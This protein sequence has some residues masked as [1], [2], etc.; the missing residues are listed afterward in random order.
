MSCKN[1]IIG[2]TEFKSSFGWEDRL[3]Q[4]LIQIWYKEVKKEGY[5]KDK[6]KNSDIKD[7]PHIQ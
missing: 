7:L 6:L 1:K 5:A 4:F 3:R 2:L